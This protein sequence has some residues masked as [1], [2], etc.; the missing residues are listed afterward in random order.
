MRRTILGRLALWGWMLC[1]LL[2]GGGVAGAQGVSGQIEGTV[3][4]EQGLVLPGVT[5]T[6]RNAESGVVRTVVTESDGAYRFGAVPPGRYTMRAELS[7]FATQ[8]VRELT[9][10][11][12]LTIRQ[13]FKLPV[14]GMA[15]TVT[16]SGTPTVVDTTKAE[17]SGVVT[18]EQIAVLPINSR[19]YLSLALLMPGTT[20]DGTRSF[21]A[22]V[23][24]GG[25]VTFNSTANIVDG[26]YNN[27]PEDGEPQQNFPEDAVEEFKVTNAQYKAEY[28]LATGGVIQVVTKSGTNIVHGSAFEYFRDK[29]L[30]EKG[31]FEQEKPEFRRHQVGGSI[32]GPIKKDRIHFF[33][34]AERTQITEFYTVNTN[35]PQFYSSVEGTFRKPSTRGLYF[36]RVDWQLSNAQT[37]FARYA[38]EDERS[39]CNNCGGTTAGTASFDQEVPRRALVIGHTWTSGRRLSDFRFQFAPA[40]FYGVAAGKPVWKDFGQWPTERTSRLG[41]SYNFPSLSWG[42]GYDEVGPEERWQFKETFAISFSS[43]DLKFG[44]DYSYMP[45]DH[46]IA[47]NFQGSYTFLRDQPFD[48]NDP[49]SVASLTG[50]TLFSASFPPQ[51]NTH[52]T[53]YYAG[54][55]QDDWRVRRNVTA[56]LGLRYER[57]YGAANEDLDPSIFPTPISYIDVSKRGDRNNFGP[58][59]GLAWDIADNGRTVVR[60]GYGLYYGHVRILGNLNEFNNLRSFS[61]TINNPSYPDP[62]GG[63]DPQEFIVS[64][65][66]NITVV[67]NDYVQP[68]AHQYSAGM[69][70]QLGAVFA[71]HLDAIYT[72]TNHDRKTLDINARDPVTR[73]RPDPVFSRVDRN[74]STAEIRHRAMYLKLEKRYSRRTQFTVSYSYVNSR[75]NGP[76]SRYLDPFDLSLDW[77]PSNA[78][79]RHALVSSA[80]VLLPWGITLG[81]VWSLRSQVPWS[82][83]AGRDLNGDGFNTDLVPGTTRNAGSRDLDLAAV[84]AW[85]APN[86][87]GAIAADQIESSRINLMDMRASKAVRLAGRTRV[88]IMAQAFNLFNTRNL[89]AQFGG[90][91][92]ANSQSSSFGRIL[93]A[94][95]ARQVELAVKF[96]W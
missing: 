85:R 1:V 37:V 23:N 47:G 25:A 77:G 74:Q 50:A 4:D 48:P 83:T 31:V 15:E 86:G 70:W 91:R 90:G 24:V 55:V 14:Q 66:A 40:S 65:P 27:W 51:V 82:A 6:L 76:G 41:R 7:G 80:S 45:Y 94:R 29:A 39:E 92:V 68:Y 78:E 11:I 49:A 52:N 67:A 43:H 88:E 16:V 38:H 35:L 62:Y 54:F 53:Q 81:T 75:D 19:Q 87:L 96:N 71:A 72:N 56:S 36:A 12:G 10:T 21:F 59:A 17:V 89:Q 95:P 61:V 5:L 73:L 93:T 79:R 13:D 34:A 20:Q 33:A 28:G 26:V 3:R 46:E 69:S 30:N 63:R 18:R 58:R 8:D 32:G 44:G 2:P 64:G 22:T 60:A 57:L 9:V 84:N 42:S